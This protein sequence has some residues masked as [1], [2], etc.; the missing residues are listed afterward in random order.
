[1]HKVLIR[2]LQIEDASISW[3]WRNDPVVWKYTG[4]KP[5][6]KVTEEIEKRWLEEN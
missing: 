5:N 6:I 1:M 3:K 2:P 4:S